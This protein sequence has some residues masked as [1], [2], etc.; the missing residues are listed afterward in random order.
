[1][2]PMYLCKLVRL[3]KIEILY[4]TYFLMSKFMDN[5]MKPVKALIGLFLTLLLF[6]C[7]TQ[8]AFS[9][10]TCPAI[11]EEY[12]LSDK[13]MTNLAMSFDYAKDMGF[14]YTLAAI[15][16][17]ESSAGINTDADDKLSA[18]HHQVLKTHALQF[19]GMADTPENQL[20]VADYLDSNFGLSATIAL[21]EFLWW[22]ERHDGNW[23]NAVRS[24]NRGYY[25]R[26]PLASI[27][28]F[29]YAM[30]VR[31]M[32][33]FFEKNCNWHDQQIPEFK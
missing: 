32:V 31:A 25:W 14:G 8:P 1:M 23:F 18:G 4:P 19:F 24:Y 33:K 11:Q 30:K 2:L 29:K 12:N 10:Y 26:N 16:Y 7:Q 17:V 27:T 21:Q 5:A 9:F 15:S 6:A 22:Y 13:Q 20:T 3:V 28:S